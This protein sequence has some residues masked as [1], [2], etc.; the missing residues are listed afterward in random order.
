VCDR[1]TFDQ[2]HIAVRATANVG[3]ILGLA[4]RAEHGKPPL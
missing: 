2:R 1:E 4:L 3:Q